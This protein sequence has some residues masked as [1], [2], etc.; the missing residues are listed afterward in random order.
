MPDSSRPPAPAPPAAPQDDNDLRGYY[1][2]QLVRSA[3]TQMIT[4]ALAVAAGIGLAIAVGHAIGGIAG[5]P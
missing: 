4:M 3:A 1:F 2:G 5:S